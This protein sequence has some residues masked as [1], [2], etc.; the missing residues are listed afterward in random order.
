MER[1]HGSGPATTISLAG[2]LET[3]HQAEQECQ[4]Q[5]LRTLTLYQLVPGSSRSNKSVE[6]LRFKATG[7]T[8]P[9]SIEEGYTFYYDKPWCEAGQF[10]PR[11]GAGRLASWGNACCTVRNT[12]VGGPYH[13]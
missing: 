12:R 5:E 8:H 13:T 6:Q 3:M 9:Y 4:I 7:K 10:H 2:R 11:D 1:L